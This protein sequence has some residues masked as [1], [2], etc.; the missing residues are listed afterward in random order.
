MDG[1]TF[2]HNTIKQ[3]FVIHVNIFSDA[4]KKLVRDELAII[5][6][7]EDKVYGNS[8]LYS[9]KKTLK[10]FLERYS[11][12]SEMT[13]KGMVGE[14]LTHVLLGFY[15]KNM[16]SSNPYFNME[17]KSIKKGFDVVLYDSETKEIWITEVKSGHSKKKEAK[18]KN[19]ELLNLAKNDLKKR[20]N[21]NNDAIWENAINGARV[22]LGEGELK[23]VIIKILEKDLTEV[24]EKVSVSGTK[25]VILVSVLYEATIGSIEVKDIEE[26]QSKISD[27]KVFKKFVL[28]TI[29]KETIEKV[30][31]F[32]ESELLL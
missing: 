8:E 28:I 20:L 14:L 30:V 5:C 6:H 24:N 23:K 16:K 11:T 9:Y 1:V 12:K 18:E 15:M 17:E 32:L 29:Q 4:I 31:S 27:S 2:L 19:T 7:G 3:S 25:N 21:E 22:A 26:I 13:K 10:N